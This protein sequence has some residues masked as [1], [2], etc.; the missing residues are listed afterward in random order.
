MEAQ[1]HMEYIPTG[2]ALHQALNELV[3]RL[4]HGRAAHFA[5]RI[6]VSKVTAHHWLNEGGVPT[7]DALL[8]MAGQAGVSLD[9]LMTGD[10]A[11]WEPPQAAQEALFRFQRPSRK[12]PRQ[13]D[14]LAI[15]SALAE[16]TQHIVPVSVSEAA[17]RLG[18]DPRQ[19]YANANREA[20]E[21]GSRWCEHMRRRGEDGNRS[22][23]DAIAAA[24]EAMLSEGVGITLR[25]LN[26][27]VEKPALSRTRRII[28]VLQEAKLEIEHRRGTILSH[29]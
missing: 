26:S 10:L 13:L 28:D 18:V 22:G 29:A 12:T 20:R 21:L 2:N 7:M 14:W 19:L 5:R 23:R 11:G 1:C 8:S 6:G 25:E 17:I 16:M 3:V 27:R 4:D 24:C 9:K 15:R